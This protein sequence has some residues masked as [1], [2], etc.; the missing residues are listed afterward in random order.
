MREELVGRSRPER[1]NIVPR[2]FAAFITLPF[3]LLTAL[4][5]TAHLSVYVPLAV[6]GHRFAGVASLASIAWLVSLES[7]L[8]SSPP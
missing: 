6:L 2:V 3:R 4:F 1:A 7:T 8:H 5:R